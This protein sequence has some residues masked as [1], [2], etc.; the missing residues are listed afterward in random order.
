VRQRRVP[1][2]LTIDRFD[3]IPLG[4]PQRWDVVEGVLGNRPA[5]SGREVPESFAA[6]QYLSLSD[7]EE[8]SRPAF[9]QFRGGFDLVEGGPSPGPPEDYTIEFETQVFA[10]DFPEPRRIDLRLLLSAMLIEMAAATASLDHPMWRPPPA[11][12]TIL[13][14]TPVMAASAWSRTV[15]PIDA[16]GG[17]VAELHEAIARQDRPDLMVVEAWEMTG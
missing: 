10:K 12:V 16:G 6:G 17:T 2:G 13:P 11:Q 9:Q 4:A 5:P 14:E 7:D 3:R 15:V 8:L 1:L